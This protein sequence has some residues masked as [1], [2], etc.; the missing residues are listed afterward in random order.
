MFRLREFSSSQVAQRIELAGASPPRGAPLLSIGANHPRAGFVHDR[1]ES[2]LGTGEGVFAKARRAFERWEAF[3]LGWARVANADARIRV[4]ETIAVEFVTFGLW[5]LNVS[6]I[7][8]TIDT[9]ELFGFVYSTTPLHV[10]EGEE[11]FLLTFDLTSGKVKYE[12][13]A[14]SRPRYWMVRLGS[15]IAR[16]L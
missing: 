11:R 2:V 5:S 6:R 12:L 8:E 9:P 1:S 13:E 3:N 4:G 16:S 7:V 15:P 14:F 10:E